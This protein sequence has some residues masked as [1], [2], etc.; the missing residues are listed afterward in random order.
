MDEDTRIDDV[1]RRA[2][3]AMRY[4]DEE[5]VRWIIGEVHES[6]RCLVHIAAQILSRKDD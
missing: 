6:K 1:I 5:K 4:D 2:A 3:A